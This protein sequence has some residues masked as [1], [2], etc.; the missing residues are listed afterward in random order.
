MAGIAV[1]AAYQSTPGV[2]YLTK[3]NT[4]IA[5]V[6]VTPSSVAQQDATATNDHFTFGQCTYY[7]SMRYHQLSGQWV[8]WSGK[9]YQWA[10]GARQFGWVVSSKPRTPSI[11]VLQPGV[12]G[13]GWLGQVAIV[14]SINPDGSVLTSGWNWYGTYGGGW[15]RLSVVTF[16]PGSGVSFVWHP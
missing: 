4:K 16:R 3:T 8:P 9:A 12:Q 14:E 13:A 5:R 6:Y 2:V 7:A 10:Y 15:A 1:Y 11:I